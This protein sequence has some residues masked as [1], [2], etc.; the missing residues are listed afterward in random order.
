MCS[1]FLSCTNSRMNL[2][3]LFHYRL[4]RFTDFP[5]N[6]LIYFV[7]YRT[8]LVVMRKG[9]GRGTPSGHHPSDQPG[10]IVYNY[11]PFVTILLRYNTM[12]NRDR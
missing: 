5:Q 3:Y 1:E 10:T 7:A 8:V 9:G 2:F 4:Y 6:K 12:E 11:S